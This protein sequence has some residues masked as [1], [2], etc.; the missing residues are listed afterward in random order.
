MACTNYVYYIPLFIF[1][2]GCKNHNP[3]S[4]SEEVNNRQDFKTIDIQPQKS[5]SLKTDDFINAVHFVSLE[6]TEESEF[7]EI[8]QLESLIDRYIILDKTTNQILFFSKEG[9]FLK[10][11]SPDD[12]ALPMPYEKVVDFALDHQNKKL[13]FNDLHSAN[14]FE[15]SL[16][17]DFLRVYEKK[18]IDYNI[19][20]N[21]HVN[22]YQLSYLAFR[23]SDRNQENPHNII[24]FKDNQ[25]RRQYLPFDA[26]IINRDDVYGANNYFFESGHLVFFVK[27]YSENIYCF[28]ESGEMF[29]AFRFNFPNHLNIPNDFTQNEKYSKK[30]KLFVKKNGA[31]IYLI[32]DFFQLDDKLVF[33]LKGGTYSDAFLYD[34]SNKSLV[35][36]TRYV[37]DS[38]TNF[39][40]ILGNDIL[41]VDDEKILSSISSK[42]F[43]D[44][45][46]TRSAQ[47]SNMH[48]MPKE[49]K[50]IYARGND[51]NPI[52]LLTDLKRDILYNKEF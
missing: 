46:N 12:D 50:E 17:G 28:D 52:L 1:I 33:K 48:T 38:T 10:K 11:I 43:I 13:Y 31:K 22:E 30:R 5:I 9:K 15:F 37:S 23:K 40:P 27:P 35:S 25:I 32:T 21:H 3:K 2:I 41:G 29:R 47:G 4:L 49:I 44:L 16:N 7:S 42:N 6:T 8:T 34:L 24:V 19:R 45:V 18:E 39:L 14:I 36:L 51:Q 26:S 20:E